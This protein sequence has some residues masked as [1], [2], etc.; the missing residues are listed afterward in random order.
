MSNITSERCIDGEPE[1]TGFV[2]S[3]RSAL[4]ELL[5][6]TSNLD[7]NLKHVRSVACVFNENGK[8]AT[9]V[10]GWVTVYVVIS[11]VIL[12]NMLIAIMSNAVTY[13]QQD[14]GWR[15][16]RVSHITYTIVGNWI[17]IRPP[18]EVSR[19]NSLRGVSTRFNSLQLCKDSIPQGM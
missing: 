18:E 8:N 3:F 17:V 1:L 5:V 19:S 11:T 7:T 6:M 2:T 13:G 12:L 14:K 15:Q 9:G 10:K 16:Y 4:Y